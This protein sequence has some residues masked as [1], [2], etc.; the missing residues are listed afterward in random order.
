MQAMWSDGKSGS[1]D[2]WEGYSA[3]LYYTYSILRKKIE[4]T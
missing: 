3:L 2:P 1:I 4:V